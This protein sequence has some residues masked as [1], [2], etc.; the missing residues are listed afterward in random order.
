MTALDQWSRWARMWPA[1]AVLEGL[2]D[3]TQYE[4]YARAQPDAAERIRHLDFLRHALDGLGRLRAGANPLAAFLET[5]DRA[6][7]DDTRGGL[8][9]LP[10]AVGDDK[11]AVRLL[12]I[13]RA[14][15]LEFPIVFCPRLERKLRLPGEP[16]VFLDRKLG[17]ALAGRDPDRRLTYPTLGL[18]LH[19]AEHARAERSEELRLLYVAMTRAEER[20]I[21]VGQAENP[22]VKRMHWREAAALAP[23]PTP[24]HDRLAAF[25]LADLLGPI[26]EAAFADP[27]NI[28]PG[29]LTIQYGADLRF[30]TAATEGT[31]AAW[32]D[33][34]RD[35]M[36]ESRDLP[37]PPADLQIAPTPAPP[38]LLPQHARAPQLSRVP[39]K[40]TVTRLLREQHASIPPDGLYDEDHTEDLF[41]EEE[42]RRSV[43]T[44]GV[45]LRDR[46]PAW[47]DQPASGPA[48]EEPVLR[49][50]LTHALLAAIELSADLDLDRLRELARGLLAEGRLGLPADSDPAL[51]E[52]IDYAAIAWFFRTEVGAA[53]LAEPGRVSRELPFTRRRSALDFDSA[54]PPEC[55]GEAV[56]VQGIIDLVI[57]HGDRAAILDYK[58][59]R[60][61]G[62]TDA[63]ERATARHAPQLEQYREALAASWALPMACVSAGLV[64]LDARHIVWLPE[65][66]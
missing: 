12:S 31:L 62:R 23:E 29:A 36:A 14:K 66:E 8:G 55:A 42:A 11:D 51:L 52:L 53:M 40:T 22:E 57:D 46:R 47:I 1:R 5:F 56:L 2:L 65:A 43:Y 34:L 32:L 15:G 16:Q 24:A 44:V 38:R 13:H 35:A 27:I 61:A 17:L 30:A 60:L 48:A 18:T 39:A 26:V 54:L 10:E 6:A 59:D 19:R 58:T 41:A 64:L 63:R 3:Q 25:S 49:G 20:L 45:S 7:E 33:S 50:N 4:A 9:E 21:L 37:P 28:P